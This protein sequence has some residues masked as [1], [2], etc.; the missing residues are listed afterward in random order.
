MKWIDNVKEENGMV[1]DIMC[2]CV[3]RLKLKGCIIN[4]VIVSTV[5][6]VLYHSVIFGD[7]TNMFIDIGADSINLSYPQLYLNAN[8]SQGYILNNGLGQYMPGIWYTMLQPFNWV[9]LVVHDIVAAN[10]IALYLEY[11]VTAIFAYLFFRKHAGRDVVAVLGSILWTYSGY[12]VL[13]GQHGFNMPLAYFTCAMYF[14]QC[15]LDKERKGIFIVVPLT[16]LAINSYYFFY[17]SGLFM[18]LYTAGYCIIKK[19]SIKHCLRELVRLFLMGVASICIGAVGLLPSLRTFLVSARTSVAEQKTHDFLNNSQYMFSVIGRLLSNDIFGVGNDYTGYYNYYESAM[20]ACTALTIPCM[21]IM[22]RNKLYRKQTITLLV[23]GIV[24][25]CTPVTSYIFDF[26]ARKPRWTFM[27]ILLMVMCVVYCVDALMDGRFRVNKLDIAAVV[28]VYAV[29]FAALMWGDRSGIADVK[30]EPFIMVVVCTV[31]YVLLLKLISGRY[32]AGLLA[33]MVV[34]EVVVSNYACVNNRVCI[35]RQMLTDGLYNDGTE[36]LLEY[37]SDDDICRVNKTYDSVFFNDEMVQGYNGL[38]V[39][40]PTNSQWLISFYQS[41]GY[42]LMNGKI[43]YVRIGTDRSVYNTL[44]GVR[45]IVAREG[46]VVPDNYTRI[47]ALGDKVLYYNEQSVGF[48]YIYSDEISKS[49]YDG[50]SIEDREKSLSGYYYVTDDTNNSEEKPVDIDGVDVDK[51]L[52]ALRDNSAYDVSLDGDT[53]ELSIDNPYEDEAMLCVPVIYD[54]NWC[55]YVDGVK[56][57]IAN[58]NGGL[59]GIDL[60]DFGTG[61]H[62]VTLCYDAREYR[63]GGVI[64]LASLALVLG[65]C[66]FVYKRR[67]SENGRIIPYTA[68]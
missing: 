53:L 30:K 58:I 35:T 31:I 66:C 51:A 54:T 65:A 16:F 38:G 15:M 63:Y 59:V 24:A 8:L 18:A 26:D 48:G 52:A 56:T 33:A 61:K 55:A 17:M 45:Y 68:I 57:E 10:L 12:M 1:R 7:N 11:L 46:D 21:V 49:Q 41:L 42:E 37:I 62:E 29:F 9:R 34:L 40:N 6:V 60:S 23:I 64:S 32:A 4:V 2:E 43:H 19:C 20:L 5:F 3:N 14:L 27:L 13:W 44:L 47:Y 25:L 39:Y 67:L 50:L 28:S 36:E 22:I